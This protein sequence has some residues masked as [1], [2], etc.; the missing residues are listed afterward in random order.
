MCGLIESQHV[1]SG[2]IADKQSGNIQSMSQIKKNS[3]W[4]ENDWIDSQTFFT[5]FIIKVLQ[6]IIITQKELIFI[7][8]GSVVGRGCQTLMV[9]VLWKGKALPIAWKTIQAPKGHFPQE[10]HLALLSCVESILKQLPQV[11]C[12][13]L[14]DGEYDG[15]LW[16]QQLR[17]LGFEYVL[18]TAKDTLMSDENGEIFQ[19]KNLSVGNETH[20]YIPDCQT[21]KNVKTHFVMWH[22]KPF[23]DPIY[24]LTNLEV[25][26]MAIG[27]Y[28]KRFKIETLFKDFKSQGFHI[29]QSKL[30]IPDRIDRLLIVCSLCYLWLIGLGSILIVKT[31]WIKKVYKPQKD[32]FNL[33]TIGKRL[34]NYLN[35]NGLAIPDIFK[36]LVT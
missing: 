29:H 1:S 24:L 35:K 20:L 14:G 32:T 18:R 6:N 5:P 11:R 19:G 7:I 10:D 21:S 34:F 4:L 8:D 26:M 12:M 25:G 3:R 23:K 27:Y 31:K 9:S 13:M 22:E 28:R 15:S 2:K 30:T 16:I 33:F 36:S 17:D